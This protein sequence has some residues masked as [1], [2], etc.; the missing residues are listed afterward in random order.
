MLPRD[1]SVGDKFKEL[2][3]ND[4]LGAKV[5]ACLELWSFQDSS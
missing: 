2:L 4:P 3:N 1:G 5:R